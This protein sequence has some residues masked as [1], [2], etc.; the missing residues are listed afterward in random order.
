MDNKNEKNK[1]VFES[2]SSEE[3]VSGKMISLLIVMMVSFL[4]IV[5]CIINLLQSYNSEKNN[6]IIE[7][8]ESTTT[9]AVSE[10]AI[11]TEPRVTVSEYILN[12]EQISQF[13]YEQIIEAEDAEGCWS[14][15]ESDARPGYSGTG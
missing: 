1:S 12:A 4:A 10:T 9:P 14:L 15:T 13:E 3:K 7:E 5:I 6:K 2:V 8:P 11:T